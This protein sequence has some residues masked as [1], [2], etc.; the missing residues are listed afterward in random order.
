MK[1]IAAVLL[2]F[3]LLI[4]MTACGAATVKET[5]APTVTT[6]ATAPTVVTQTTV[7][8][9][10]P[11]A[12][13]SAAAET[14]TEE[15]SEMLLKINDTAVTV[16]WSDNAAVAALKEAA[17]E[18]DIVIDMSMYGGFE[19]VGSLGMT[20]PAEDEQITTAA[21]DIVLYFA[22]QIVVFYGSNSWAY[23]PLGKITDKTPDQ[24][25]DLLSNGDVTLTISL[26]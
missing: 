5:S 20:L 6:I 26:T 18:R 24:L 12:E 15:G 22:D 8:T 9:D 13:Q 23:T 21:G 3:I 1:R 16:D 25:S 14:I 4:L 2:L 10:A 7:Q 11:A 17:G 19:Q